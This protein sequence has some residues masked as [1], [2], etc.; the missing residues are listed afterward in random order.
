MANLNTPLCF[1]GLNLRNRIV[2]PPMWSGQ[3][4]PDGTITDRIV[5]YHRVRAAAGC[6]L[7][8]VEHSF[9]HPYGRHSAT[10]IGIQDDAKVEGF[11]RLAS[12]VRAEGAVIAVQ[13]THAG[14]KASSALI[15]R[16][17]LGPSSV[18]VPQQT[19]GETPDALSLDQIG[20]VVS[21]FGQAA[22]RARDAGFQAVEVHAAHGF[23]LSEFL[24]P[25][26][27]LRTDQYGGSEENRSRIHCE[28][29]SEIRRHL[30][31]GF[32]IFVR[33]GVDDDMEGGVDIATA[34]RVARRLSENGADLIDVSGGLQGP[35]L[36]C[37]ESGYF[38]A[39]AQAIKAR[40][41]VPVIVTG[42]IKETALADSIIR[43][44][45]ADL[46]GIG[47]AMLEDAEWARKAIQEIPTCTLV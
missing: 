1:A 27:N 2:M 32:P 21:A 43:D 12:A 35:K 4:M 22:V 3:A 42:G 30:G 5:E 10:Q 44:G 19:N 46:V 39:H 26:T 36:A 15:G 11:R 18:R 6:G 28:I 25:L 40:V 29:L 38:V 24:S 7:V 9:V 41:K 20:E 23:L 16:N 34:V 45:R 47:R 17:P 37:K 8:I 33:L 31:E 14:A 13:I